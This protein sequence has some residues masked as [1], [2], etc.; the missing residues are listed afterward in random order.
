M[1]AFT[2]R[3]EVD[4]FRADLVL[5][6]RHLKIRDGVAS[7]QQLASQRRKWIDVTGNRRADDAEPRHE[8]RRCRYSLLSDRR[9]LGL[10]D[11]RYCDPSGSRCTSRRYAMPRL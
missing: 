8:T 5:E 1:V 2:N 4:P 10:V 6:I 7:R 9:R 3:M 11:S